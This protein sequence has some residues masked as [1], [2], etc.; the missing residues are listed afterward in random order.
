[1]PLRPNTAAKRA[2]S[3]P[4]DPMKIC[5]ALLAVLALVAV[6]CQRIPPSVSIPGYDEKKAAEEKADSHTLGA[7]D[8]PPAF[9]PAETAQ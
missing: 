5:P 1:M 4:I 8:N 9:F 2:L 6:S 7:S 3:S